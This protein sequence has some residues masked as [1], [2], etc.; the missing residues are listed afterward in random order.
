MVK[1]GLPSLIVVMGVLY[2]FVIPDEPQAVKLLF[3]L[4]PMWLIIA[5]GYLHMTSSRKRC[6]WMIGTGL[7]FCMLGDGLLMGWFIIGLAAFLIG[8]LFYVAAFI[9]R[10]R[11]SAIRFFMLIPILA[12]ASFM[13]WHLLQALIQ[14]DNY[15]MAAAVL[16]YI[17]VI[18]FMIWSA[19]MTG[20]KL[21][22][23]GSVLF[24]VSDSIL[25]WDRFVS[26]VVFAGPLIMLTYYTAQ[27][28]IASS[29]RTIAQDTRTAAT[30]SVGRI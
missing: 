19:I 22:M 16:V 2:I 30:H 4:I 14:A 10:W 8:H 29:L 15:V 20:N 28:L 9:S 1:Y 11:F 26:E 24:A 23:A 21:A 3:K 18:S 27:F 12:Y 25:A 17:I 7:F 6:H 13:S 5:Y